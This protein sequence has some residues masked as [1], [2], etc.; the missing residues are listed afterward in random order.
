MCVSLA[1]SSGC[2]QDADTPESECPMFSAGV[3]QPVVV[4]SSFERIAGVSEMRYQVVIDASGVYWFDRRGTLYALPRE[5]DGTPIVLREAPSE[6]FEV[7][8]MIGDDEA[9]YWGEATTP[10]E[11]GPREP[12]PPPPPGRLYSIPKTGGDATLLLEGSDYLLTPLAAVDDRIVARRSYRDEAFLAVA[13]DGSES[14]P[15]AP[16]VPAEQAKVIDGRLYWIVEGEDSNDVD[17]YY[18]DLWRAKLDGSDEQHI[19]RVE[20]WDFLAGDGLVLWRQEREH[21][22]PLILDQ[23]YVL[24][25]EQTDCVTPLPARGETISFDAVMDGH[26]VYWYSFNGLEG[27]SPGD[28]PGVMPLIR[29]DLRNGKLE[30]ITTPGFKA[31]LGD[32]IVGQTDDQLYILVGDGELVAID[33][34]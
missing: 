28:V 13:K 23:N 16:D 17:G 7:L 27:F 4:E 21:L 22:D 10:P 26:H 19:A 9:L 5:G 31:V 11:L 18:Q 1:L 30:Q 6:E 32:N 12:G 20:G 29:V 8:G 2:E 25:D 15:I 24:L 3:K 34:P 14:K 33:K